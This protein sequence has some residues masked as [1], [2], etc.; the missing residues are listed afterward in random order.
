[1]KGVTLMSSK[2]L[3]TG[4]LRRHSSTQFLTVEA[5]NVDPDD[6]RSV[7]VLMFDWSSGFPVIL[8]MVDPSTVTIPPNQYR[9]FRSFQLPA[10][11]FA[12]EVRIL[13]PKDRDVVVNVFGLSDIAFDPQEGN[14]AMQHDLAVVKLK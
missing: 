13:H 4:V 11:L 3:S 12:Y 1:M 7:S 6:A 2:F 8:P 9:T 10:T 14:N 5:L